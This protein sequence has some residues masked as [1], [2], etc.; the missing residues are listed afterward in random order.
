MLFFKNKGVRLL[1]KELKTIT[2][3][4]Y[5][6]INN[7]NYNSFRVERKITACCKKHPRCR[8]EAECV[9]LWDTWSERAPIIYE[10]IAFE[11]MLARGTPLGWIPILT[12]G[13][14]RDSWV[15]PQSTLTEEIK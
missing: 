13:I 10:P 4:G 11:K 5:E 1:K 3:I 9:A 7:Q 6:K 15:L 8:N 14:Q 2:K 12:L